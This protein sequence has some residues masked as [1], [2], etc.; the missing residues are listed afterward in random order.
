MLI[1]VVGAL[2]VAAAIS[3]SSTGPAQAPA[4][5]PDLPKS[6]APATHDLRG[7]VSLAGPVGVL[8]SRTETVNGTSDPAC[9]GQRQY[10][11]IMNGTVVTVSDDHGRTLA[12]G[13]LGPGRAGNLRI[14]G[15]PAA[16]CLF[17]ILV[18]D[19]PADEASYR[20]KI[21]GR[22]PVVVDN[23]PEKRVV[24]TYLLLDEDPGV[25]PPSADLPPQIPQVVTVP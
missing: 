14:A 6:A 9:W 5:P 21:A 20:V 15:E 16:S 11:D 10:Q 3:P 23:T 18:T 17:P 8:V 7:F 1:G 12:H 4:P 13:S 25:A 2:V 22:K 19:L 24:Y